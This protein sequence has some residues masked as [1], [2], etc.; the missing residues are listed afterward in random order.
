[1]DKGAKKLQAEKLYR[2][3]AYSNRQI[4]TMCEVSDKTVGNWAKE[5]GWKKDLSQRVRQRTREKVLEPVD[6]TEPVSDEQIVEDNAS[7]IASIVRDHQSTARRLREVGDT[8]LGKC[9][10]LLDDDIIEQLES[11]IFSLGQ[12]EE[13]DAP[14][15]PNYESIGKTLSHAAKAIES[16]VKLE[17]QAFSMDEKDEEPKRPG[18]DLDDDELTARIEQLMRESKGES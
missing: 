8:L 1:M 7:V 5:G 3:G 2:T 11:V 6:S 12:G 4:A 9:A 14:P 18:E 13:A 17:R 15:L 10:A 16:A